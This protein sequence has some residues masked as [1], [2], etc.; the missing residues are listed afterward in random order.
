MS[1]HRYQ[2]IEHWIKSGLQ[3]QRWRRGERLPSIRALCQQFGVS[4][5]TVQHAF[6]RLEAQRLIEARPRSGYFVLPEAVAAVSVGESHSTAVANQSKPSQP[7]NV[8]VNRILFDV[9]ERGAAFDLCPPNINQDTTSHPLPEDARHRDSGLM[10]LNRCLGRA[11]R[12]QQGHHHLYYDSP[13]G[14]AGL[15]HQIA[16][17]YRHRSTALALDELSITSGCQHGLFLA[18]M[19]VCQPGDVVAVESPGFYGVLQLLEQ[20]QLQ[21]LEIPTNHRH[22]M[23]ITALANTLE[24]W[25]IKAVIVTPA[26]ATPTGAVMPLVAQQALLALAD[27]HDFAVIEDDIY[28]ETAFDLVPEPLKA[29]DRNQRVILCG[30][31][32]KCLSKALR[33]GWIAGAR[34][35][36]QILRLKLVSQLAGSRSQQQGLAEFISDGGLVRHLK[37]YRQQLQQQQSELIALLEPWKISTPTVPRGG[38]TLWV[39][40]PEHV[41][42]LRLYP[43]ALT[44]G[45]AMTPGPLFS[46]SGA[47]RNGLRLSYAHPWTPARMEALETLRKLTTE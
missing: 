3:E 38:L 21:A 47:F 14:D 28:A 24:H 40:L 1:P 30:S 7:M 13:A 8:T 9:M 31:Y 19:A 26:Y 39:T 46:A 16:E 10:A 22:G 15:R 37:R 25:P 5:I 17:R 33:L 11:L 6:Q 29:L 41:D 44:S 27:Q 2:R 20:L 34:W 18:L 4:K 36:Q 43:Q 35:H 45:I 32:S 12:Q 42:T 23:D